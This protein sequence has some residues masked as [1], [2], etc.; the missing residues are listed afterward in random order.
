MNVMK[1]FSLEQMELIGGGSWM[2]WI[3]LG[4]IGVTLA[5]SLVPAIIITPVGLLANTSCIAWGAWRGLDDIGAY[6]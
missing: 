3:D 5:T 2:G 4:C 6:N 1:E